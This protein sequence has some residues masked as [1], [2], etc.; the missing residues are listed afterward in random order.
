MPKL[1]R[2]IIVE[3]P[4]TLDQ[5]NVDQ[6]AW[7][8]YVDLPDGQMRR[9]LQDLGIIEGT[10][11]VCKQAA[12]SGNPKSFLVRGATI[13]IRT[14]DSKNV[15]ITTEE[16]KDSDEVSETQIEEKETETNKE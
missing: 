14:E 2:K 11:V 12:P 4:K 9:R 7:V 13:A 6:T 1:K 5:L 3:N 10:R 16:P 15:F 8:K